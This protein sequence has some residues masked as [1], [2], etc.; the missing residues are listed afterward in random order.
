MSFF[1]GVYYNSIELT[2]TQIGIIFALGTISSIITILPSGL[3]N[4]RLKSKTLIGISLA[5]IAIFYFGL[6]QTHDFYLIAL[7][8]VIG[9]IGK[10]IYA[11]SSESLFYKS[12]NKEHVSKRIGIYQGL[13]YF[14]TGLGMI[15]AGFFLEKDL[16]FEKIFI[17]IAV[18]FLVMTIIS[19]ITLPK[20][21]TSQFPLLQYKKDIFR[22]K[23]LFF[24]LII[25]LFAIHWGAESTTYGLF[26]K[27]TLNLTKLQMGLYMGTAIITM[28]LTV[29]IISKKIHQWKTQYILV[30]G[31]FMSG[32]GHILMTINKP[33]ISAIFRIIHEIGDAAT[34]FFIIYGIAQLFDLK[35]VGGNASIF[36]FT[37]TIGSAT[38]AIIFGPMGESLGYHVPLIV[39]G[40]TTLLAL[41][42]T[43][44]F[45]HHFDHNHEYS[46]NRPKR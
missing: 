4:D 14:M 41:A 11:T 19:Q 35:R 25:F 17:I 3:S 1:L 7:I 13:N 40:A 45:L 8:S 5:L 32:S 29:Q 6:S 31:L 46:T 42:L 23:I 18:L 12:T 44:Q 39:S 34:F 27:E 38:G 24:L 22:P 26:L 20:T 10:T 36:T 30:V 28:A 9:G 2:G 21:K 43:L 15:A 33:I 16:A 37:A